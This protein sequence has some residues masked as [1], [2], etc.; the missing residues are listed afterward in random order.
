MTTEESK[1]IRQCITHSHSEQ[2]LRVQ[3]KD[4]SMV[5]WDAEG[6]EYVQCQFD[7][8]CMVDITDLEYTEEEIR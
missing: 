6:R 7:P 8:N 3:I 2:D 1:F 4:Q 5:F